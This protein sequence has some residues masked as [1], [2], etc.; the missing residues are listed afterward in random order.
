VEQEVEEGE[1]WRGEEVEGLEVEEGDRREEEGEE[2]A[3]EEDVALGRF[4]CCGPPR[5]TV[6][7]VLN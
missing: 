5:R 4:S 2:V 1:A 6:H 7:I 3:L